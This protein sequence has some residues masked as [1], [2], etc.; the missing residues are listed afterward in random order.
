MLYHGEANLQKDGTPLDPL[1][2]S[3][4]SFLDPVLQSFFSSSDDPERSHDRALKGL[5]LVQASP[6]RLASPS[7][8]RL[9]QELW[10]L[11]FPNPVGSAAGFDKNAEVPLVSPVLG[12]GFT[13][14]GTL[15]AQAQQ[16]NPEPRVF[17]LAEDQACINHYGFPNIGAAAAA[18]RLGRLLKGQQCPIPF[19]INIGKSTK[20]PLENAVNDYLESSTQLL[21][22]ADYLVVNVSCPNTPELR[23]LQEVERLGKLL[24]ALITQTTQFAQQTVTSPKPVLVKIAPDLSQAEIQEIARLALDV[25]IA[26]LIATNTTTERPGLRNP[27]NQAGG[28]SGRPLAKRATEVLRMLFQAVEGKLPLIGVGGIF[29]AADAYERICAGAS[30]VQ[31]YTGLI[32]KGPFL[33]RRIARGLSRILDRQ[34]LSNIRDAVG[35]KV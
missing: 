32:Y 2:R 33:P 27:V 18:Q 20:T 11:R 12:F 15:T 16:G 8:P 31:V 4:F 10:G 1:P 34:G 35:S 26:G 19:G 25:G 17:R 22:F 24:E 3:F 5:R 21:P 23:K 6:V 9:S 29:S 13:E 30:L 14:A 28:L 7:I